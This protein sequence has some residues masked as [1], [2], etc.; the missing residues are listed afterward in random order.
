LTDAAIHSNWETP[1]V[2]VRV[3]RVMLLYFERTYGRSRLETLWRDAALPLPLSYVQDASNFASHRFFERV[4]DALVAG[5]GDA[6]FLR[7]ANAGIATP[8]SVGFAYHL[9]R[10]LGTP[11]ILFEK[12]I[13]LSPTYNRVGRFVIERSGPTSMVLSYKSSVREHGPNLCRA[14]MAQFA[15]LPA[16]WGLPAAEVREECCQVEGADCCRYSLSWTNPLRSWLKYVGASAGI[17]AG[18]GFSAAGL[19]D[20][21]FAVPLLFVAGS[22]LGAFFDV[23]RDRRRLEEQLS[24]QNEGLARSLE[25]LQRRSDEI[26]RANIE[27]EDRVTQRTGELSSANSRL[28]EALT[29]QKEL[30]RLKT[31]FFDNV[32][33]ELRTPLTL[34]LLTLESLQ[35]SAN[36]FP[37]PLRQ[38]HERMEKSASRL[39]KL[40]ND[41]L[42]LAKIE[43]G[44]MRIRYDP[45]DLREL[46]KGLIIPFRVLAEQ[47]SVALRLE[48]PDKVDL[49]NADPEKLDL[50]FQNLVSNAL[51]FTQAGEVVLRITQDAGYVHVAVRDTG[52]GIATSDLPIIFDRFSQADSSGTRRFGGTGIGLAIVKETVQLHGGLV[53]VESDLGQGS[54]FRVSLP[55]GT[56]HIRE[57]LRERR[58]SGVHEVPV[59]NERR[60]EQ[61]AIFGRR[62]LRGGKPGL[63]A[64]VVPTE[65]APPPAE[66][67]GGSTAPRPRILVVEDDPEIFSFLRGFL[68]PSYEVLEATDGQ[69]GLRRAIDD[70]PALIVSD[71]MMP[72]M[73]GLQMLEQL[74]ALPET[75]DIPVILLTARSDVHARVHGIASGASDYI[76]KPFAPREL[77]A[78]IEAQLRL[79]DA[80][81]RLAQS[82]RLA[83]TSLLTSG[84]AH[85]VRNPLNGLVNAL[86]PLRECLTTS[87]DPEMAIAMIEVAEEAAARI[88]HLAESLLALVRRSAT[89]IPVS[90][91]NS[92][93]AAARAL[94]WK[95]PPGVTVDVL[96]DTHDSVF[97][98]P[99]ALTQVWVNLIDNALRALTS[100]GRIEVRVA[101]DGNS[102]TTT[103]RDDGCGIAPENMDRLFEPFF[104]TRTAGEGTGLGLALSRRI[105]VTHG[106][107]MQLDSELGKGTT[108]TVRLPI[109]D[110]M[111]DDAEASLRRSVA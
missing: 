35:Q 55:R 25:E 91:K 72:V 4:V 74:R 49:I 33:H 30:D 110:P 22:A 29:A 70:Q 48:C 20:V 13:E 52:A 69:Q 12:I 111:N 96:A 54:T 11:R 67:T 65:E 19:V 36:D 46:V 77:L 40:I 41:L 51:K 107:R 68:R 81:A 59:R 95:V 37:V 1:E 84:F 109:H 97:G 17:A 47:K 80:A 5:A 18:F 27:L 2:A 21:S 61:L 94:K 6:D 101:R 103:V 86:A 44:K 57:D 50:V 63:G 106:G 28:E 45:V 53:S 23:R 43:A 82:E 75:V 99:A 98:D 85:E 76:G 90:L 108:V 66:D 56:E 71:V 88:K 89:P 83:A 102:M 100:G 60:L 79:R 64:P 87:P 105:V 3:L 62:D 16:I 92:L 58:R 8:E 7:K 26:F 38:H 42:D 9:L 78:R 32:S 14:R 93:D 31:Q 39:L 104:S 10:A 15:A 24:G 73:S 34:I